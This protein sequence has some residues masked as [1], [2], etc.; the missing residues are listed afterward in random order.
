MIYLVPDFVEDEAEFLAVK[1][2]SISLGNVKS[3]NGFISEIPD[4]VDLLAYSTVLI[5]C[6]VFG[7]FITAAKY[8]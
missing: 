5:W 7:E 3:F 8:N 1:D 6:K 4:S 2:Q